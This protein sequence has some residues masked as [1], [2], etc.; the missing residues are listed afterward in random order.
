M[1]YCLI[2]AAVAY[3]P[4]RFALARQP[5]AFEVNAA[6]YLKRDGRYEIGFVLGC[7]GGLRARDLLQLRRAA[8]SYIKFIHPQKLCQGSTDVSVKI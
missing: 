4:R 2:T 8:N 3:C 1:R 7:E 6:A 5:R